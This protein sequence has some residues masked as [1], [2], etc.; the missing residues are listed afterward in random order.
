MIVQ[1]CNEQFQNDG[2]IVD[3]VAITRKHNGG[4]AQYEWW[5]KVNSDFMRVYVPEGSKLLEASGQTREIVSPPLDY[6][7]L[8]F[9]RDPQVEQNNQDAKIDEESGTKIYQEKNKS[10]FANWVYVSPGESVTVTYKYLLPFKLTFDPLH[11]PVDS[12]STL[13]QKQSG[14]PGS[15]LFSNIKLPDSN[16]I[17][18]KWP[19]NPKSDGQN[20]SLETTLD[21]DRVVGLAIGKR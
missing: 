3:T 2:S 19:D 11:H 4:N 14:S 10:V 18:W 8:G 6:A 12:F 9:K 13:Y 16:A 7:A 17:I 1:Y 15:K 20:Y 21:I 5:N